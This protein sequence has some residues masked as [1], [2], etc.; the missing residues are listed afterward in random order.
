[1]KSHAIVLWPI[2]YTRTC[3]ADYACNSDLI[4]EK[5]RIL[6]NAGNLLAGLSLDV[7][8]AVAGSPVVAGLAPDLLVSVR[9]CIAR[10]SSET[11]Q[12]GSGH[13]EDWTGSVRH[14]CLHRNLEHGQQPRMPVG[15]QKITVVLKG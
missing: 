7:L 10:D 5:F 11:P 6:A 9:N 1:M 3:I 2:G 12:A 14:L 8:K 15:S 4:E 13:L